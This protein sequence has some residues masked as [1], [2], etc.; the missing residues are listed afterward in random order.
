VASLDDAMAQ[1]D[2]FAAAIWSNFDTSPRQVLELVLD[3]VA[4]DSLAP[5]TCHLER[6]ENVR[7]VCLNGCG[8]KTLRGFPFL[9]ELRRLELCNNE[10]TE[11]GP[12]LDAGISE[13]WLQE[14]YLD[15][16]K[17]SQLEELYLMAFPK[18]QRLDLD[19]NPVCSCQPLTL[20]GS[21]FAA[22]PALKFLN[23]LDIEDEPMPT[24]WAPELH[25][26]DPD[27]EKFDPE[28]KKFEAYDDD[29][30]RADDAR[31]LALA[32]ST[33]PRLGAAS[34]ARV[35]SQDC[36]R[37]ILQLLRLLHTRWPVRIDVRAGLYIDRIS[38]SYSDETL[39]VC[40]GKG[41]AWQT[42]FLLQPGELLNRVHLRVGDA[43]DSVQFTTTHGRKSPK[44]GGAGGHA[45]TL[46]IAGEAQA[47]QGFASLLMLRDDDEGCWLQEVQPLGTPSEV[48]AAQVRDLRLLFRETFAEMHTYEF[49]DPFSAAGNVTI[50]DEDEYDLP[51]DFGGD[52]DEY[53]EDGE[54]GWDEDEW[55]EDDFED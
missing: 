36:W 11:L 24:H 20:R 3:G 5:Y 18:L 44:Y 21:I 52:E 39:R 19:D 55:D 1:G 14:L 17:F 37:R 6:F 34:P 51:S 12:L 26:D 48:S 33:H 50:A 30:A 25:V 35:L 16:N 41:G 28:L 42:P 43:V 29:D 2:E 53:D 15:D 54:D 10:L 31:A 4:V 46:G 32:M 23:R 9:P 22:A 49:A 13:S 47:K 45:I 8:L 38:I 7:T 27:F 40:G